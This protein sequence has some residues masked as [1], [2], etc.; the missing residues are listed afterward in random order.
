MVCKKEGNV[1]TVHVFGVLHFVGSDY[2]WPL[3][4]NSTRDRSFTYWF[5]PCR[6]FNLTADM[7]V[8][9][10]SIPGTALT[11]Y[12]NQLYHDYLIKMFIIFQDKSSTNTEGYW[13][14]LHSTSGTGCAKSGR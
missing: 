1:S 3:V 6:Y 7:L 10:T 9:A 2:S 12:N 14:S 8:V 4:K 5:Q 13:S 11:Q